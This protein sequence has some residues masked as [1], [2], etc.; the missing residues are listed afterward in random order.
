MAL[1]SASEL[2]QTQ[3]N[4]EQARAELSEAVQ[5]LSERLNVKARL[6]RGARQRGRQV[7]DF[8]KQNTR[9]I[10]IAAAALAAVVGVAVVWRRSR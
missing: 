5:A 7:A 1:L 10:V 3:R 4:I 6:S 2:K 9:G 8:S